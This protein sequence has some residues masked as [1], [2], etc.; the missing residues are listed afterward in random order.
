MR[1]LGDATLA[2]LYPPRDPDAESAELLRD[3]LRHYVV[4]SWP[5]VTPAATYTPGWHIDAICELLE[6]VSSG[7]IKR[8]IINIPPRHGKSTLVA[9]D[10]PT[11]HWL[12]NPSTRWMFASYAQRLSTR[13]S[14][15]CRRLIESQ[16]GSEAADPT[17]IQRVGYQG[18]LRALG[19]SWALQGD[20]NEK[21]RFEN[22]AS[23]YRL[24]TSVGGT[25]TG[26][27]GDIIVVDDPH[28]ANEVQ[29]DTQ[30]EAVIDWLDG[31][32]STRLNDP[33]T[34]AVVV[35]M[36]RLHERDA[37]GH[38]LAQGG[39]EHLCLPARYE[40]KHPFVW[41]DDPRIAAGD[42]LWPEQFGEEELA[43]LETTLGT[44]G[45]AGQLQQRP[46]PQDGGMFKSDWWKRYPAGTD[47]ERALPLEGLETVQSWDFR[48]SDAKDRND[49][50]V[51]QLWG[52]HGAD[53]YLLGQVR[54]R[55]SFTESQKA[56]KAMTAWAAEHP[57]VGLRRGSAKLVEEKANGAAIIQTLRREV[58][59]II[60]IKPT[61]SKEARASAVTPM[62]EAGNVFL[63]PGD[64]IPAPPGYEPTA[65]S[66][67]TGEAQAFP[68]GA[69]DDQ[70]DALSQV[71]AWHAPRQRPP[72]DK[73]KRERRRRVETL[74]GDILEAGM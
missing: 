22:S 47:W 52:F 51:G 8:A 73:T 3:S 71:L 5:I 45:A 29:S 6:A 15:A 62:V 60:S 40:P 70:V 64:W 39:Y 43:K 26:E 23:G 27:G 44:M 69:H 56:V 11:W 24:A 7:D 38:L 63:P 10:W 67:L 25:A 34:G 54:G 59:G 18:V 2:A 31:T 12:R 72:A 41:P 21:T 9:V 16:G 37:T 42:L 14:L 48:F 61:E 57:N 58:S 35:V 36:Q 50:V 55:L 30:R 13:D 20:Q 46:T 68:R 17:L 74:A 53:C 4:D 66:A 19:Q 28:K 65:V 49:W 32:M 1:S 33:K